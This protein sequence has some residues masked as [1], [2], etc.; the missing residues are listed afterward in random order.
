MKNTRDIVTIYTAIK[1]KLLEE[2]RCPKD[3]VP[4]DILGAMAIAATTQE[5]S[6]LDRSRERG[7]NYIIIDDRKASLVLKIMREH[8]TMR[9]EQLLSI[10]DRRADELSSE[11]YRELRMNNEMVRGHLM[12]LWQEPNPWV[13]EV[14]I[15]DWID[16]YLYEKKMP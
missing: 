11:Q 4:E 13:R 2:G 8:E 6:D 15:N 16:Q 10:I 9:V 1:S 5:W 3:I 12:A 7:E 14:I